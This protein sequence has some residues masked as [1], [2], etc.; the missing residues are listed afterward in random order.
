MFS[1]FKKWLFRRIKTLLVRSDGIGYCDE[2]ILEVIHDGKVVERRVA[3]GRCPTNAGFAA[4]AARVGGI[5]EDAFTY[6]AVGTGSTGEL[7]T[8]TTL[9]AEITTGGLARAA[10]T[11]TRVTTTVAD[12]TLQLVYEWAATAEHLVRECGAFNL[13]AAGDMLARK[14]FGLVTVPNGDHLKLTYKFPFSAA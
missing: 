14:T 3:R 1:R 10:A 8:N 13:A 9:E 2:A 6:L 11:V 7:A 4:V 12:D 5:A